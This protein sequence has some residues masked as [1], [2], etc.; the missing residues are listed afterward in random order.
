MKIRTSILILG[1]ISLPGFRVYS[2]DKLIE[3]YKVSLWFGTRDVSRDSLQN[4]ENLDFMNYL[5]SSPDLAEYQYLGIST[6][7]W[8]RGKWEADLKIAMFDDFAPNNLNLKAQYFP[9]QNLGLSVGFYSYP[10]LLNDFSTYHRINDLGFYGDLNTNFRQRRVHETGL[11]VGLVLPINYRPF[12]CMI[13]LNGGI[14]SLSTFK[15]IVGQKQ[16]NSNFRK[17]I[18]YST[19][20][21]PAFFL[22]PEIELNFDCFKIR[23]SKVGIQI[24]S[25]WYTVYRSID[26]ERTTY[27]WTSI[28]PTKER[29]NSPIHHFEKFELDFGIYL[30]W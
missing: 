14:S 27:E 9:L 19:L 15:E 11:I 2:Q 13:Q 21:S 22:F 1:L 28:A 12:H 18:N 5:H 10:Q 26:Y 17:E 20:I 4:N 6:H 7:L 30:I 8:F 29:I 23:D 3:K 16:I 25:S 24:Q